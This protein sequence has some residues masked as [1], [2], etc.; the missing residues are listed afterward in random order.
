MLLVA[1]SWRKSV[2]E[3][4]KQLWDGSSSSIEAITNLMADGIMLDSSEP[5]PAADELQ[6][7]FKKLLSAIMIPQAWYLSPAQLH[8][9]L[10]R[11]R[12][13]SPCKYTAAWQANAQYR[14]RFRAIKALGLTGPVHSFITSPKRPMTSDTAA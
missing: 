12:A 4:S 8:P 11:V 9:V 5:L 2:A 10:I 3:A 14:K 7:Q 13:K 6:A 1:E